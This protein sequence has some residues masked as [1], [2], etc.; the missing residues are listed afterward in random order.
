MFGYGVLLR[1]LV[2]RGPVDAVASSAGEARLAQEEAE[3][4]VSHDEL[5]QMYD[6]MTTIMQCDERLRNLMGSAADRLP[7]FIDDE[8]ARR[9]NAI[10]TDYSTK[11]HI[12]PSEVDYKA[13]GDMHDWT[14]RAA[15]AGMALRCDLEEFIMAA[16]RFNPDD[17]LYWER[18]FD[19][20]K[21]N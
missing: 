13:I 12:A 11:R 6:V 3:M 9:L 2:P 18:V 5:V 16:K 19:L 17:V 10:Q 20:A 4:S 8:K 14:M 21:M 7:Y 15:K 1:L